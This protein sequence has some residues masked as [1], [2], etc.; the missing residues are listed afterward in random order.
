V[1]TSLGQH[2]L[3]YLCSHLKNSKEKK[4]KC[5]AR[6]RDHWNLLV[7]DKGSEGKVQSIF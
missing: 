5:P 3:Y 1:P 7:T 4:E 6:L 2:H